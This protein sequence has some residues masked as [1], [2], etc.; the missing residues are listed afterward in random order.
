MLDLHYFFKIYF[1]CFFICHGR[2][3]F[4]DPVAVRHSLEILSDLAMM[5][6]YAVAM[7]LGNLLKLMFLGILISF[8]VHGN[9]SHLSFPSHT[10]HF[11]LKHA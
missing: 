1:S 3:S 7:A 2:V 6:P 8:L 5:D 10:I 11:V 9:Y 4:A